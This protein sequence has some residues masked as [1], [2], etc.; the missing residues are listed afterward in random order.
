L[1][2]LWVVV[3]I[4]CEF[5]VFFH[6]PSD[7]RWPE[8][9][10]QPVINKHHNL[11]KVGA[12]GPDAQLQNPATSAS[13]WFRYDSNM[14]YLSKSWSVVSRFHPNVVISLGDTLASGRYVTSDGEYDKYYRAF[15]ATLPH[16]TSVPFYFMP[17]N[18]DMGLGVSPSFSKDARRFFEEHF[19]P[20]NQVVS[21]SGHKFVLL[22][23][24]GLVEEDY[25]RH[26]HGKTYDQWT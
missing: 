20:L 19:G 15:E 6:S 3:V 25:R 8:N 24:P 21:I 5:G 18:N 14:A 12:F 2:L 4:R 13:L 11:F 10:L 16:D 26:A 1:R 7:C 17:G 23:A 9:V 22:N